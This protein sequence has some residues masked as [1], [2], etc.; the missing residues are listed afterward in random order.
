MYLEA[1]NV[2]CAQCSWGIG[3][4]CPYL[5]KQ[6]SSSPQQCNPTQPVPHHDL[7]GGDYRQ[8]GTPA[9]STHPP[10]PPHLFLD[11]CWWH[12]C[13][14]GR[15]HLVGFC[16]A[17]CCVAAVWLQLE[18]LPVRATVAAWHVRA[19]G[20]CCVS[21]PVCL[22]ICLSVCLSVCL[23]YARCRWS[24][25]VQTSLISASHC[26]VGTMCALLGRTPSRPPALGLASLGSR[27]VTS[28][29]ACPTGSTPPYPVRWSW[30]SGCSLLAS[31]AP[32]SWGLRGHSRPAPP[33]PIPPS[34]LTLS[35]YRQ[36]L[37]ATQGLW[38]D[39]PTLGSAQQCS[40]WWNWGG[41]S[42]APRRRHVPRG[43]VVWGKGRRGG[44]GEGTER[45]CV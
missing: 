45:W 5:F 16:R 37:G 30:R 33:P 2:T 10:S 44:V 4:S 28:R 41:G 32:G 24:C 25:P 29:A 43:E 3:G 20:D 21:V 26:A 40:A 19:R 36:R 38:P 1:E 8:V 22:S 15:W 11:A 7:P 35:R 34:T 9:A 31:S 27:A 12:L 6:N 14:G 13:C 18:L 23:R 42:G 39:V 17:A